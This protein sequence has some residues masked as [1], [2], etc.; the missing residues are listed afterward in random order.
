MDL[1]FSE[2][3][4]NYKCIGGG[5]CISIRRSFPMSRDGGSVLLKVE[6]EEI[7]HTYVHTH[8]YVG[9]YTECL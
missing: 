7:S 3:A 8:T 2:Y 9:L 1:L 5:D 6:G 4:N